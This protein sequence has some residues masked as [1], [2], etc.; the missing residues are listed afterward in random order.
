VR[1]G[2]FAGLR[3]QLRNYGGTALHAA[4]TVD[5]DNELGL[6]LAS[7]RQ[8]ISSFIAVKMGPT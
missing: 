1:V 3:R 8:E 2:A 4:L 7:R 6:V 5:Q